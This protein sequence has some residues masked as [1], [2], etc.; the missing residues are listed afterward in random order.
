MIEE[1]KHKCEDSER[2]S[3]LFESSAY[4][5]LHKLTQQQIIRIRVTT[6]LA[7]FF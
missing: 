6:F 7:I 4:Y 1:D 3:E 2:A 5:V